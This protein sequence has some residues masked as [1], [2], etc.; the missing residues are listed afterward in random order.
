MDNHHNNFALLFL[1]S[2]FQVSSHISPVCL[3]KPGVAF[4]KQNCVSN[5]WGKDKFGAEGRWE[6]EGGLMESVNI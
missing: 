5:G 3:P 2:S 1:A 4:N 6:G